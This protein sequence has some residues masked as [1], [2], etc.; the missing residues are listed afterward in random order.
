MMSGVFDS[1]IGGMSVIFELRKFCPRADLIYYA[2]KK[3]CPYGTKS[4]QE[5]IRLV[6]ADIA[7]LRE[8]GATHALI[9]CCTASTV[10]CS[11]TPAEQ[12]F[13]TPILAPTA[14]AAA[15]A[16][17][18]GKIGVVCTDATAESGEF[19]RQI[20]RTRPGA[21]VYTLPLQS[22]VREV[23]RMGLGHS[24]LLCERAPRPRK[25]SDP[26]YKELARMCAPLLHTDIDTL[27]LGCTHFPHLTGTFSDIFRGVRIV[28][29]ARVGA[30][31]LADVTDPR[32]SGITRIIE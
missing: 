8:A 29:C 27:V 26:L 18:N 20:K 22:L 4:R 10:Y 14:D 5:I 30:E 19:E 3:N 23:E 1:G 9:A 32:G 2:D 24:E 7:K 25:K 11:L 28:S 12:K 31:L 16:T 6:R 17:E 15:A 13:L 21:A